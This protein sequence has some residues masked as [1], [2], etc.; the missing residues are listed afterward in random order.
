MIDWSYVEHNL[1]DL[2]ELIYSLVFFKLLDSSKPLLV[3]IKLYTAEIQD[4][5]DLFVLLQLRNL[6]PRPKNKGNEFWIF[7][8]N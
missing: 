6:N 7:L 3:Y 8:W 5:N 1:M 4:L 2:D